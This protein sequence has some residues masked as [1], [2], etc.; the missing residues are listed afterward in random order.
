[1]D[2]TFGSHR[3]RARLIFQALSLSLISSLPSL[4]SPS[5]PSFPFSPGNA[6]LVWLKTTSSFLRSFFS[7]LIHLTFSEAPPK[8]L[9]T[10]RGSPGKLGATPPFKDSGRLQK[11]KGG[12][13][14]RIRMGVLSLSVES[15]SSPPH[16]L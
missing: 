10:C 13:A 14:L 5:F 6:R 9:E 4:F 15:D 11:S 3:L 16:G 12:K 2:F 7:S 1:M 8:S